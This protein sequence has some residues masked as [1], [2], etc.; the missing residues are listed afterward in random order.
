MVVT[1]RTDRE[2]LHGEEPSLEPSRGQWVPSFPLTKKAELGHL[3]RDLGTITHLRNAHI[4]RGR[5]SYLV[6][7]K[8]GYPNRKRTT[9][10]RE[11]QENIL[12]MKI[13]E[14]SLIVKIEKQNRK[15]QV[16]KC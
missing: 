7:R 15:H 6:R 13:S 10:P 11:V 5:A 16:W 12:L 3:H 1:P 9:V 4:P 8:Q 2:H 14:L